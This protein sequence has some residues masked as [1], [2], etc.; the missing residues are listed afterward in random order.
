MYDTLLN[1]L[2]NTLVFTLVREQWHRN[3]GGCIKEVDLGKSLK[4]FSRKLLSVFQKR[5]IIGRLLKF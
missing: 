5:S 3:E 4:A 1:T 2:L